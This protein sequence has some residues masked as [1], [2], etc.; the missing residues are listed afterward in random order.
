MKVLL[1]S[2]SEVA[3][4]LPMQACIT[5]MAEALQATARGEVTLPLRQVTMLPGNLGALASMPAFAPSL[6]GIGVKVITAFPGNRGTAY[7]SHQGAVLLFEAERGTLQAIV[8]ASEVT[9][10][11]T[12]AVSAVATRALAR[13]EAADLAILGSGVQ[14]RTH[15]EA[16]L[17]VRKIRQVRVWSPTA[18]HRDAFAQ[19]EALRLGVTIQPMASAQSAVSKADLICTVTGARQPVLKGKWIAPGAHVNAVGSSIKTARELDT[20]AVRRARLF[21]DRRESAV[22]E[23]GDF[24]I[25]KA[26]GAI[27]DDHIRG[28]LGDVL[29]ERI[30]GRESPEDITVFKSLGLAVEDLAAARLIYQSAR[31]RGVGTWVELG[32]GRHAAD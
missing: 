2:Q 25:P 4:L 9:A 14:A 8:D 7:D 30:P 24:L 31:D 6:G 1:V 12:A 11:R 15:L 29:L 19:R 21:V 16:M 10:I 28:E 32:G 3:Q 26:E 22:N 20:D 5:A 23:A 17:A 13:E 27:D 18:E